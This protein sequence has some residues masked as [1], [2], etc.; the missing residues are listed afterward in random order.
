[1]TR[2]ERVAIVFKLLYGGP[3]LTSAVDTV[4]IASSIVDALFPPTIVYGDLVDVLAEGH[5]DIDCD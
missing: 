5:H 2:S 4:D 1:M 3:P